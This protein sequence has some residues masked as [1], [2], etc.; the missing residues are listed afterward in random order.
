MNFHA[1]KK[2]RARTIQK[3]KGRQMFAYN[4]IF[5][6]WRK[7]GIIEEAPISQWYDGTLFTSPSGI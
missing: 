2:R 4:K 5:L 6:Q 1:A 7:K 3:L